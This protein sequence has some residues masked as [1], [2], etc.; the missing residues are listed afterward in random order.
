MKIG[1]SIL[2]TVAFLGLVAPASA[3]YAVYDNAVNKQ[4]TQTANNTQQILKSN[5]SIQGDVAKTLAAV[6][7]ARS[8]GQ[9]FANMGIGG[10]FNMGQAPSFGNLIGGESAM[11]FG[12]L[13]GNFQQIASAAINGMKLVNSLSGLS[14]ANAL[15]NDK[16]YRGAANTLA[17]LTGTIAG[18]SQATATR[19]TTYQGLANQLGNAPDLKGALEQNSQ[20]HLQN[21]LVSNEIVG[22]V[23]ATTAAVA[24]YNANVLAAQSGAADTMKFDSSKAAGLVGK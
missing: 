10:G 6:T 17:A 18:T 13:G 7:G 8:D 1:F 19:S 22:G 4:A 5:Q 2:A 3:Q 11:N 24:S 15:G 20:I 23:N 12:G 14:G 21:G 9:A 16:A